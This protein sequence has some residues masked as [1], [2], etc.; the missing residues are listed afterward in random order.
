MLER[1]MSTTFLQENEFFDLYRFN[2][3]TDAGDWIDE[4][5]NLI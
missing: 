5:I 1:T 2:F 3:L 4:K